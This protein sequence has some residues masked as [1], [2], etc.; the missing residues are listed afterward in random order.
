MTTKLLIHQN[1]IFD[2]LFHEHLISEEHLL[3]KIICKGD[4]IIFFCL[5]IF[6]S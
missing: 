3:M 1:S 4:M 2:S 6:H 5:N